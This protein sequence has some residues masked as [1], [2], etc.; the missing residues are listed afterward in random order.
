MQQEK[1]VL[2]SAISRLARGQI[3]TDRKGRV[4]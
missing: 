2:T 1:E 3:R 4:K